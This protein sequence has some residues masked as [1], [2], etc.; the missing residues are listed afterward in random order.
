MPR[1]VL[2]LNPVTDRLESKRDVAWSEDR[3]SLVR[4][5]LN[6]RH[7]DENGQPSYWN[8]GRYGKSFKQGSPLERYNLPRE[9]SFDSQDDRPYAPN[10]YGH[11]IREVHDIDE[12]LAEV[13]RE[14]EKFFAELHDVGLVHP[15]E[16]RVARIMM[17][18][19]DPA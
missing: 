4:W 18:G 7:L 14:Y 6:Q 10:S 17:E 11:G 9:Q 12:Y 16:V 3:E 1:F 13:R 15:D 5:M 8:D 19:E 2:A